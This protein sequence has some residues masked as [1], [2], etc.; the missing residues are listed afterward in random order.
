LQDARGA[1]RLIRVDVADYAGRARE[2]GI[3][4]RDDQARPEQLTAA[5]LPIN[6][7][8]AEASAKSAGTVAGDLQ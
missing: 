7:P 3:I 5:C 4:A 2:G 8:Y 6:M 1:D